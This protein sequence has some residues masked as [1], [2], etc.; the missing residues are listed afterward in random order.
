MNKT[1]G[2]D[3]IR[4]LFIQDLRTSALVIDSLDAYLIGKSRETK[5]DVEAYLGNHV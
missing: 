4:K 1:F 3:I 2:E 5:R